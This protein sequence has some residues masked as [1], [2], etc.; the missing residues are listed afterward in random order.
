[1][2][3]VTDRV[4]RKYCEIYHNLAV[5]VNVTGKRSLLFSQNLLF[6]MK[7]KSEIVYTIKTQERRNL[8]SCV[9]M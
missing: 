2:C 8:R 9:F 5:E 3:S 6:V 1:M 7:E 4:N